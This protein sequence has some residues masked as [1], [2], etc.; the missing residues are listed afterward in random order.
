MKQTFKFFMMAAIMAVGFIGCSNED[1]GGDP[2]KGPVNGA[3]GNAVINVYDS[4]GKT[5]AAGTATDTPSGTE[6]LNAS[7]D[8]INIYVYKDDGEMEKALPNHKL[9]TGSPRKTDN[10]K[11]VTGD[12]HPYIF[13]SQIP[14]NVPASGISAFEKQELTPSWTNNKPSIAKDNA[15][16][17]GTLW[18]GQKSTVT[19]SGTSATPE[20]F[21]MKIGRAAAKV[22]LKVNNTSGKLTASGALKGEFNISNGQANTHATW[23]L[24][25]VPTTYY[26]VGQYT[27]TTTPG[28]AGAPPAIGAKVISAAH[29]QPPV[30][31]DNTTPNPYYKSNEA[32]DLV[33]VGNNG[34]TLYTLENT[35]EYGTTDGTPGPESKQYYGNTTYLQLKIKYTPKSYANGQSGD[36]GEILNTDGSR[37]T[38]VLSGG[39]FYTAKNV[40]GQLGIYADNPTG[41]TDP[42]DP[43]SGQ[44]SDVKTYTDGFVYYKFPVK[45]NSEEGD[46]NTMLHSVIRNH[47]YNVTV[48]SIS[49]LGE[50]DP[51]VNPKEPIEEVKDVAIE[52][53]VSQWSKIDQIEDL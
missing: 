23:R 52:V 33:V 25:A 45:D 34:S 12:K 26:L 50:T 51:K 8:K 2:G 13:I 22:T 39:T 46:Q 38:G 1:I 44:Y 43:N 27:N 49:R 53:E 9:N 7:I 29:N 28:F 37:F 5:Y 36:D 10:F 32:F 15:F 31:S 4:T 18:G 20:T 14:L 11:L 21:T 40:A 17:L 48:R 30:Q 3:E 47:S 35:S 42:N 19:G 41:K 6:Q 24:G 16:A